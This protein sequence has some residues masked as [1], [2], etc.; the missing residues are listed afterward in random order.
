MPGRPGKEGTCHIASIQGR[1]L[2]HLP[3]PHLSISSGEGLPGGPPSTP[4]SRGEEGWPE[5]DS[6]LRGRR[7]P[8]KN[9]AT[10]D[11]AGRGGKLRGWSTVVGGT[12]LAAGPGEQEPVVK[13]Q[14]AIAGSTGLQG[15]PRNTRLT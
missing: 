15:R 3:T 14:L 6:M 2:A 8:R 11:A 13:R 10:E 7:L 12:D 5:G 4:A 9:E 1:M